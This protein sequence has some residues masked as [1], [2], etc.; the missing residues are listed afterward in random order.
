MM[1]STP[2]DKTDNTP[3]IPNRTALYIG[4]GQVAAPP[5]GATGY[6]EQER[7]LLRYAA[8]HGLDVVERYNAA[9][10]S[11]HDVAV[12][13]RLIA[14]AQDDRFDAV[15]VASRAV[16][17][18]DDSAYERIHDLLSEVGVRYSSTSPAKRPTKGNERALSR[19]YCRVTLDKAS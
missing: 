9:A 4:G 10:P 18:A 16:L 17:A 11:E 3:P 12:I 5:A 15:L 14:G 6:A 2:P 7:R 19:L 1:E 8:T 13:G